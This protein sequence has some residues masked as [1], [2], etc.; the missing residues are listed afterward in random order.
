MTK[1]LPVA[2]PALRGNEKRYVLDCLESGWISSSGEYVRRFEEALAAFFEVK[3]AVACCNGTVALHLALLAAGIGAGDEVIVPTA[4]FVASANAALYAGAQPVLV[5]CDHDSWQLD[6][7]RVRE[8]ITP[9]TKAIMPVHLYGHP[10]PMDEVLAI[11]EEHGLVVVE[12]AAEAHGARYK[13]RPVGSIGDVATLSFYGN[14]IVT[15]GEGGALLTNDRK[16]AEKALSLRGQG[17]DPV[18]RYWFTTVGYNYRLT[19]IQ[20]A[21]G[22][23]QMEDIGWHLGKRNAVATWYSHLIPKLMPD[24]ISQ[25]EQP[26]AQ[27]AHWMNT[28][29]LPV[30]F[31]LTLDETIGQLLANG[32]ESRPF[33]PPLHLLP[34]YAGQPNPACPVSEELG[35]RGISL[36]SSSQL[37]VEDVERVLLTLDGLRSSRVH[38]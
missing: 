30:D 10:A 37:Q 29:L 16:L 13:G 18:R 27:P 38:R 7:E 32:I 12:D 5:D 34:I 2:E 21:I 24:L 25:V 11:A 20:A 9:R 31:G 8:A 26:W 35:R 14:K 22:L 19:N 1:F 33:F 4:T 3:Y 28:F 36:P 17:Q 6:P 23:A 15:C